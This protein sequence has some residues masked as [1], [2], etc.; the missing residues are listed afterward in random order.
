MYVS[1]G[2]SQPDIYV[3]NVVGQ[4]EAQAR[5]L[6]DKLAVTVLPVDS[7]D[8]AGTVVEQSIPEFGVDGTPNVVKFN[9]P[10]T[11]KVST[12]NAPETEVSVTFIVPNGITK[13]AAAT[14]RSYINGN[15]KMTTTIDNIRYA[16]TV[17]VPVTGTGIQRVTIEAVNND[18]MKKI[19]IGEYEVN[20]DTGASTEIE[21]NTRGFLTLFESADADAAPVT[22][23]SPY[24][25]W[26]DGGD[27]IDD[28]FW[29]DI[30][31]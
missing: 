24:D 18:T 22:T 17:S 11:I 7:K 14:F 2:P 15:V 31:N 5:A 4:T 3:Q 20:F 6:L 21:F 26:S 27:I 12:G 10:I 9:T 16:A 19:E 13:S 28:P 30:F 25:P 8:I 23:T 29:Q 1:S